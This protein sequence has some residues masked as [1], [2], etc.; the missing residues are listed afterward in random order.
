MVGDD[1]LTL[2]EVLMTVIMLGVI[3]SAIA[4]ALLVTIGPDQQATDRLVASHDGQLLALHLPQDLQSADPTVADTA[5]GV[6]IA[7]SG[8]VAGTNVLRLSWNQQTTSYAVSY[9]TVPVDDKWQLV[10]YACTNAGPVSRL[11]VAHDL[12]DGTSASAFAAIDGAVVSITVVGRTGREF[13]VSGSRRTPDN[14]CR[15][16]DLSL[17]YTELAQEDPAGHLIA[18]VLTTVELEGPCSGIQLLVRFSPTSA[19]QTLSLGSS[20]TPRTAT[21]GKDT[22]TWSVG[23]KSFDVVRADGQPLTGPPPAVL[24]ITPY[25]E[26]CT[27]TSI[28]PNPSSVMLDGASNLA[29]DVAVS[30]ATTGACAELELVF[31][32]GNPA[33][34]TDEPPL[35][36]GA[37][38]PYGATIARTAHTWAAGTRTLRVREVATGTELGSV[39]LTVQPYVCSVQQV[40]ANPNPV[41][42]TGQGASTRLAGN[43]VVT[44]TTT[45]PCSGLQLRYR[46]RNSDVTVALTGGPTSW[47]ATIPGGGS[48]RWDAGDHVLTV[49]IGGSPTTPTATLVVT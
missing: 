6:T 2:P 34:G 28:T 16:T 3:M 13:T 36:L 9:R 37:A 1:G 11:V 22:F 17:A 23:D 47:T 20:G 43:V 29:Q 46:P 35:A 10:R 44:V 21:I 25:V 41:G 48:V 40:Q 19:V 12:A 26:P 4:G 33:D 38:A 49:L 39:N 7:C 27:V 14:E 18:D 31:D 45:G 24:T 5:P 15:V 42:T 32:D 8:T 30:V